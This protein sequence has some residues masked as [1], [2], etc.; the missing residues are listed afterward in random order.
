MARLVEGRLE[1]QCGRTEARV[2]SLETAGDVTWI[3]SETLFDVEPEFGEELGACRPVPAV[4][5]ER[6]SQVARWS[7]GR[8]KLD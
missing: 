3:T 4:L 5:P 2:T 1:V 7:A 8:W 6:R